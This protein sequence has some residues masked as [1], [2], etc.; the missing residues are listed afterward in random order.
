MLPE[1]LDFKPPL[2]APVLIAQRPETGV[3]DTLGPQRE[4]VGTFDN[5]ELVARAD[6]QSVQHPYRQGDLAF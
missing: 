3:F 6:P 2:P 5:F 4:T 1:V